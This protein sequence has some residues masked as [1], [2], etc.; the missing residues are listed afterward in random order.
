MTRMEAEIVVD[1]DKVDPIVAK[2]VEAGFEIEVI[3]WPDDWDDTPSS[4]IVALTGKKFDIRPVAQRLAPGI[5]LVGLS[6]ML[7]HRR[8]D[9]FPHPFRFPLRLAASPEPADLGVMPGAVTATHEKAFQ[10]RRSSL[11]AIVLSAAATALSTFLFNLI[12]VKPAPLKLNPQ[13]SINGLTQS[14][15]RSGAH[16]SRKQSGAARL[17][18]GIVASCSNSWQR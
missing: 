3:D 4:T 10:S 9:Q 1:R 12:Q 5:D 16:I 13:A 14:T 7:A 18:T 15:E 11:V 17:A 6:G 8:N 2:F